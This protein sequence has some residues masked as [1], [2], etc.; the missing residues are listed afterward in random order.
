MENRNGPIISVIICSY[1]TKEITLK[2][3]DCLKKS[4]DFLGKPVETI[5]VE[6][7]TDGTGKYVSKNY[8][9]VKVI[10][11]GENTGFSKGNNIGLKAVNKNAQNVLFL[12]SD[13]LVKQET[14]SKSLEF[15]ERHG[16]ADVLGCK[17]ILGNGK[18]QPSAGFL[19]TPFSVFT[20]IMGLDVVLP[21]VSRL[22]PQFHPKYKSFF[23]ID[24]KVGWVM[25]AYLFMKRDVVDKTH[26]YDENF[27]AY[28]E[29][30]EWCR[31]IKIAGFNVYYTPGFEITHL[32]KA[33]SGGDWRTPTIKEIQG[34]FYYIKKYYKNDFWWLNLLI[35]FAV[36]LRQVA[37]FVVGNRVRS[38]IYREAAQN[39]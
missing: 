10:E 34:S 31:R 15:F 29:E 22:F 2:C 12:N 23:A 6:N 35:K 4:I 28:M 18:F 24:K 38:D 32:D 36:R 39:L 13:A 14:L 19:P 25:G 21:F 16:D 11:P 26:G 9:W 3:L 7:G 5:L 8:D 30:V 27:F 37:F 1:N 20:W 17:L 33:S